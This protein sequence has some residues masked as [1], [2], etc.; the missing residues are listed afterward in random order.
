MEQLKDLLEKTLLT[1]GLNQVN[2]LTLIRENWEAIVGG[3][4]ANFCHP[5]KIKNKVLYIEVVSPVWSHKLSMEKAAIKKKLLN[6]CSLDDI[7]FQLT[8]STK[9]LL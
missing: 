6:F 5:L 1:F 8:N 4:E 3:R 7:R 2:D 9:G